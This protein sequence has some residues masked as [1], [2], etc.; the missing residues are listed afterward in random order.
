MY[1]EMYQLFCAVAYSALFSLKFF[2]VRTPINYWYIYS[3]VIKLELG[4]NKN[5]N[6]L[7]NELRTC[8]LN[9]S[10]MDNKHYNKI[11]NGTVEELIAEF[12]DVCYFDSFTFLKTIQVFEERVKDEVLQEVDTMKTTKV[13]CPC[14]SKYSLRHQLRHN[15]GV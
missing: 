8:A 6:G 15:K 5:K 10:K 3:N 1:R 13:I 9:N 4:K 12:T 2:K 14:G 11:K 7:K